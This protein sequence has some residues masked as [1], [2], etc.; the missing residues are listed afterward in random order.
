LITYRGIVNTWECDQMGHM[1]VQFYVDKHAA[2]LAN[3]ANAIGITPSYQRQTGSRFAARRDHI[4]FKGEV[5]AGAVLSMQSRIV[6]AGDT[7]VRS[8][9][10]L[11]DAE[12]GKLSASFDT[13]AELHNVKTNTLQPLSA[14]THRLIDGMLDAKAGDAPQEP[15]DYATFLPEREPEGM[16]ESYRGAVDTWECDPFGCMA[17]RF[18]TARFSDAAGHVYDAI[19]VS[20]KSMRENRLGSAALD[21]KTTYFA[22]LHAGDVVVNRTCFI[23]IGNKTLT[24][25]HRLSNAGTGELVATI[26]IVSV[27]FDL[28]KRKSIPLPDDIRAKAETMLIK[29]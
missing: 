11:L 15:E 14:E 22:P 1:N 2:A 28:E 25:Y 5:H 27:M 16:F 7:W 9:S 21:Y 10:E 8:Y 4:Q 26:E 29:A 19:G 18:Y 13:M 24:F 12:T 20:A 6:D 3:V 23:N 17:P